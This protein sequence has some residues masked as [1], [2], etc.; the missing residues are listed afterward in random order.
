MHLDAAFAAAAL[1]LDRIEGGQFVLGAWRGRRLVGAIGCEREARVKV[2]HI[3]HVIGMMVRPE[4]RGRGI[5]AM[6]LEACIDEAR[7]AGLEMLTLTVTAENDS[8]IRLYER[9]RF[10][11]YG[12]LAR[13]LKIGSRYHNKLHMALTL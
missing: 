13:A 6:L 12:T 11:S 1:G 5:G 7:H 10:V 3:G 9:H 2:R 4:S 8:A